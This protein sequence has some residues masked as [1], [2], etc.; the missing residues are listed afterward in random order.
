[1]TTGLRSCS[2]VMPGSWSGS[3]V[4]VRVELRSSVSGEGRG[5]GKGKVEV[6]GSGSGSGLGFDGAWL[7]GGSDHIDGLVGLHA[8]HELVLAVN[9]HHCV[10]G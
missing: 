8:H 5:K 7:L 10:R 2:A 9:A 6:E 1:M 3:V 4:R